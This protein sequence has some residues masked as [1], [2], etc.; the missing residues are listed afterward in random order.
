MLSEITMKT[1]TSSFISLVIWFTLSYKTCDG[2]Y[3]EIIKVV[4]TSI[5]LIMKAGTILEPYYNPQDIKTTNDTGLLNN[6]EDDVFFKLERMEKNIAQSF[7]DMFEKLENT[8]NKTI[9]S[10]IAMNLEATVINMG[11]EFENIVRTAQKVKDGL[12]VQD[13]YNMDKLRRSSDEIHKF[14]RNIVG[15]IREKFRSVDYL[16]YVKVN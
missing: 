10:L 1:I 11:E 16:T 14:K 9:S 13:I 2:Q 12:F 5:N 6:K 8:P 3:L 7:K 4:G 15:I